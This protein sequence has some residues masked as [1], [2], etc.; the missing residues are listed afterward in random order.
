MKAKV[1]LCFLIVGL[2]KVQEKSPSIMGGTCV[3][4]TM[5]VEGDS[6]GACVW[7][8]LERERDLEVC[9]FT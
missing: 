2:S 1:L 4:G 9:Y 8:F 5:E 7:E 6:G 3:Y